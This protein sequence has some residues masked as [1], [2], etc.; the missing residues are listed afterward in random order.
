MEYRV[1]RDM[2]VILT[3]AVLSLLA[4][5]YGDAA[6]ADEA[7]V[8]RAEDAFGQAKIHN[9]TAALD[10]LVSESYIG[11][12]HWGM[13]R[14]KAALIDVYREFKTDSLEPSGVTVRVS[15]DFATVDGTMVELYGSTK[16]KY[17]FVRVWVRQGSSPGRVVPVKDEDGPPGQGYL[18]L[19]LRA[20]WFSHGTQPIPGWTQRFR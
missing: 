16:V 20:D 19:A 9:D 12:N 1:E 15:G 10:R 5:S 7:D 8:L 17:L 4:T 2:N 13:R 14:N 3:T 11:V 6:K 18:R